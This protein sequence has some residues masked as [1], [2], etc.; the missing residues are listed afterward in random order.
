MMRI[1]SKIAAAALVGAVTLAT[2]AAQA[3]YP[4]RPIRVII[5]YSPG[6]SSDAVGRIVG[7]KLGESLKQQF[8]IDNRPGASGSLGREIVAKAAPDGYTL[9]IG[10]SPHTINVHVLK[11]VPYDPIRDFTPIT[12][13]ASAPQ[14]LVIHSGLPP[15]NLKEFI[16]AA[17]AQPGKF[18]YGSGGSGAIT[19]LAGELFKLATR[20][21]LVHVP[22]KSIGIATG[23]VIG[24]QMHAAFPT[25]PGVVAHARAGRLRTLGIT[26][27][28]RSSALPDVPTFEENGVSGMIVANWFGVFAPARLPP[29]LLATLH[30]AVLDAMNS[31]DVRGK[32][33]NLSLDINTITPQAFDAFLKQELDKWGKVVKAAGIKAD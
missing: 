23:D 25:L 11:H 20:V 4:L 30:K 7:Q 29:D 12:L 14:A 13:L 31:P 19:H 17:T 1:T 22:Y 16:A 27:A 10:D 15:Q 24:G 6:G 33:N 8:V 2:T 28:K 32:L 9:L 3:N 18:N 21:N 26:S 5:P